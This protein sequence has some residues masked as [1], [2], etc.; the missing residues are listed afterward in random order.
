MS[1]G[2]DICP[3]VLKGSLAGRKGFFM[4]A[5]KCHGDERKYRAIPAPVILTIPNANR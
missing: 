1:P 2:L 3:W 4:H 5:L